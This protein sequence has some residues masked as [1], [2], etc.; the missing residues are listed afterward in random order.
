MSQKA[1]YKPKELAEVAGVTIRT[2]HHYDRIG[3]LRPAR[4]VAGYRVY[5]EDDLLRLQ[6]IAVLKFVGLSLVEIKAVLGRAPVEVREALEFQR[7]VLAEK[8]K[9][10][11]KALRVIEIAET[12]GY[13]RESLLQ[14]MEA[15]KM[16][17]RKE[18][19][20]DYYS[21]EARAKIVETQRTMTPEMMADSQ[22]QWRELIAEVEEAALSEDPSSP[23]ARS[24]AE[25]W[26]K[27]IQGF[28]QNDPEIKAGLSK[29][30]ADK[31]SWPAD[32]K[33]PYSDRAGEFICKAQALLNKL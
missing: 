5:N 15:L 31:K 20:L 18:W 22:R 4:T 23:R 3:L 19:M 12:R 11:D 16:A 33:K 28:T 1:K 6:H 25:R 29:L 26:Q 9:Q 10:I 7:A 2:L 21:P 30:Y 24:L 27:L 14:C 17:E 13:D 8:R 32:F